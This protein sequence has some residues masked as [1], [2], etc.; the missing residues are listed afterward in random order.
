MNDWKGFH[1][2]AQLK[3][4]INPAN[5]FVSTA[6]DE[7]N[8]AGGPLVVNFHMGP[9][10]AERIRQSLDAKSD[11]DSYDMM[12]LQSDVY[13]LQAEA[14]MKV[15][16]DLIPGD[17]DAGRMLK[18]WD[19][20]YTSDSQAAVVFEQVV[21]A[22]QAEV[23]SRVLGKHRWKEVSDSI[24]AHC[25]HYF[26]DRVLLEYSPALNNIL[27]KNESRAV[28][29]GRVIRG[30]LSDL[31][32]ASEIPNW[33]TFENYWMNNIFF[34]GRL[35]RFLRLDHNVKPRGSRAT[36][37][38]HGIAENSFH[39]TGKRS[40]VGVS[41]RFVA[42]MSL[43][44]LLSALPGGPS[45]SPLSAWYKSDL[46]AWETF[47]SRWIHVVEANTSSSSSNKQDL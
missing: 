47:Q 21:D 8:P 26:F 3:Q 29:F 4:I 46:A 16:R 10:R 34:G 7:Q 12:K 9:Y 41:Y 37:V 36:I 20:R 27:W 30:V 5:G 11:F 40:V 2:T 17:T 44:A 38:Q 28:L 13:S 24:L 19:L 43:R 31:G 42:D 25:A 39:G 45:D 23:F 1:S 22:L 15:L 18:G 35:P 33:G 14:Y 32:S 6:N